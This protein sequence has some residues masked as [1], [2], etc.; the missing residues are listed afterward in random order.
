MTGRQAGSSLRKP[1]IYKARTVQPSRSYAST[2]QGGACPLTAGNDAARC[3]LLPG[4]A[5]DGSE[6]RQAKWLLGIGLKHRI[7]DSV[8]QLDVH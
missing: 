2:P 8:R 7:F 1:S 3:R 6:S 5:T 4:R